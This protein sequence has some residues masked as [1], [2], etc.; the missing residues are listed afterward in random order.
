MKSDVAD[1][2]A[3]ERKQIAKTAQRS[4]RSEAK[5]ILTAGSALIA[6]TAF[7]FGKCT[8]LQIAY[9]LDLPIFAVWALLSDTLG[10]VWAWVHLRRVTPKIRAARDLC[11]LPVRVRAGSAR[12]AMPPTDAWRG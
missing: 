1:F 3:E 6:V 4:A 9:S 12:R 7:V 10:A 5:L 2:G 8:L 11:A